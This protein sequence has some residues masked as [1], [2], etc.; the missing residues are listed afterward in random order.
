MS[1][2]AAERWNLTQSNYLGWPPAAGKRICR[3][4]LQCHTAEASA[5]KVSAE[6]WTGRQPSCVRA[7]VVSITIDVRATCSH[8]SKGRAASLVPRVQRSM[9]WSGGLQKSSFQRAADS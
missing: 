9:R 6:E 2:D 3:R 7:L 4:E 5:A 8:S 1:R